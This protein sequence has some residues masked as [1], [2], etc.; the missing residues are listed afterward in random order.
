MTTGYSG[1]SLARKL[2]I[3]EG[4][5][6]AALGAPSHFRSLLDPLPPGVRLQ[7]GLRGRARFDVVIA[8]ARTRSE[9]G[10]RFG[11][12]R[13]RLQPNGGLWVAWP[14]RTSP[15]AGRLKESDVREHGLA[16]GLVDNKVCA[17]DEDW[18]GL[19]F[20]IR[21]EDRR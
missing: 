4:H 2:G 14:K 11:R 18:S 21:L 6:V 9:L 7:S 3:K 17:I 16:S 19:R 5:R 20:V 15:L 12:A 13:L 8:F 1:T 10:Q